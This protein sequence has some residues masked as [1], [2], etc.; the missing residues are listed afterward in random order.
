MP[1]TFYA[2]AGPMVKR[3]HFEILLDQSSNHLFCISTT[4]FPYSRH[5]PDGLNSLSSP[6]DNEVNRKPF[7]LIKT[8]AK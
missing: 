8:E 1:V 4:I 6:I 5:M 7:E 2:V 3:V